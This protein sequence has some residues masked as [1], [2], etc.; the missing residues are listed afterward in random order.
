MTQPPEVGVDWER[1]RV[2]GRRPDGR[3]GCDDWGAWC[4]ISIASWF[5]G[6]GFE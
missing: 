6:S 3:L 5:G 1:R 4:D 2:T